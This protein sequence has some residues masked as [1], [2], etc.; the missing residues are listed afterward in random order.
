[1][2]I[3][4]RGKPFTELLPSDS[5]GIVDMFT[6]RYLETVVYISTYRIATAVLVIR[7]K[8]SARQR[9]YT[10]QYFEVTHNS[11]IF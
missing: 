3:R 6:G 1:M 11:R 4:C 2:H 5:P 10:P 7:F 9:V 8:V